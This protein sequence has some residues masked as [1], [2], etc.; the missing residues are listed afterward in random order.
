MAGIYIH[1]PFC[2]GKCA[3]CDFYSTPHLGT[4]NKVI[5][6][7]TKEYI[8]RKQEL[9]E[10]VETI[11]IGGGTPSI[12]PVDTLKT[13][14]DSLPVNNINEFT[15]EANPE[16]IS[17]QTVMAWKSLGINRVSMGVQ[18]LIDGELR[19]IGRRHSSLQ[20][21]HAI[22][23]IKKHF[24]NFSLDLIYGLPS[25]T[26]G[27]WEQSLDTLLS[28]D[29]PHFSAYI[30]SFEPGTRL[31]S[32]LKK[33]QLNQCEE[34]DILAMYDYLI[35]KA[36]EKRYDHYE[37]SNFGKTD[38]HAIHNSNYWNGRQYLGLGPS[39]HSFDGFTRRINHMN[40]S[41]YIESI[42]QSGIAYEIDAETDADSYNDMIITRLR[43]SE[44]IDLNTLRADRRDMLLKRAATFIRSS[45]MEITGDHLYIKESSWLISDCIMRELIEIND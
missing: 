28:F 17:T 37:I 21:I 45:D 43:T 3:Y 12:L 23:T 44:G 30:L 42:L 38:N 20:A 8:A 40:I 19:L 1:I 22:E 41:H 13:L 9:A 4:I 29:P 18:S 39:A 31:T 2:H 15:I 27:T 6:A 35:T 36:R 26:P 5:P 7:I 16:D 33:G 10:P 14:V 25:Q 11:Y 34:E 24:D 32:M